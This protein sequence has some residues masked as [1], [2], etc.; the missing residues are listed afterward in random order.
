[1]TPSSQKL[2]RALQQ[3]KKIEGREKIIINNKQLF[4][5]GRKACEIGNKHYIKV[6]IQELE[7]NNHL[8]R[9]E[10]NKYIFEGGENGI[11]RDYR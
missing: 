1:M 11:S 6:A 8:E 5:I 10:T 9:I 4:Q 7:E 3:L 2:L